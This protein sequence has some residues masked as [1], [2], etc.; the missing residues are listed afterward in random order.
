MPTQLESVAGELKANGSRVATESN[1]GACTA[2]VRTSKNSDQVIE[3]QYNVASVVRVSLGTYDITFTVPM[4][5]TNIVATTM[6]YSSSVSG[7]NRSI[8]IFT[9]STTAVRIVVQSSSQTSLADVA[10]FNFV[11]FGGKS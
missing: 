4:D 5:N 11:V 3:A 10:G 2:W 9:I 1:G 6:G 8:D 7:L